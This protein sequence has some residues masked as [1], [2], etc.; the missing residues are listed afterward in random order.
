[1]TEPPL[2]SSPGRPLS[3]SPWIH[4]FVC[5]RFDLTLGQVVDYVTPRGALT[6]SEEKEVSYL[7]FP[8]S[9]TFVKN[10]CIYAIRMENGL[11]GCVYFRQK[12][13]PTVPRGVVQHSLVLLSVYPFITLHEDVLQVLST[14]FFQKCELSPEVPSQPRDVST[15]TFPYPS[16]ATRVVQITDTAVP[17]NITTQ[18]EILDLVWSRDIHAWPELSSNQVYELPLLGTI[19]RWVSP[20]RFHVRTAPDPLSPDPV[21]G[22]RC[23]NRPPT[24]QVHSTTQ[25]VQQ[26][27]K[28]LSGH[29]HVWSDIPL[30]TIFQRQLD[31]LPKL[32]ELL[33]ANESI[34]VLSPHPSICS[35]VV[36]GMCSLILPMQIQGSVHPYFTV[37]DTNLSK[38]SAM[39]LDKPTS[40]QFP[41]YSSIL[42]GCTNVYFAKFMSGWSNFLCCS[43]P[44]EMALDNGHTQQIPSKEQMASLPAREKVMWKFSDEFFVKKETTFVLNE[45]QTNLSK[46]LLTASPTKTKDR[47]GGVELVNNETLRRHFLNLTLDFLSPLQQCFDEIWNSMVSPLLL[48]DD[49]QALRAVFPPE[50]FLEY[51]AKNP[52]NLKKIFKRFHN[53]SIRRLYEKFLRGDMFK[54]W[55]RD[56]TFEAYRNDLLHTDMTA[57]VSRKG[58][59][60]IM[61]LF[62]KLFQDWVSVKG[63]RWIV[64]EEVE[65]GLERQLI[66]LCTALPTHLANQLRDKIEKQKTLE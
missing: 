43:G 22:V 27:L 33:I 2:N 28:S 15:V 11:N 23:S 18:K 35:G 19:L 50:I 57:M 42:L 12:R 53:K 56:T 32:W 37:Q 36:L 21:L 47:S 8:D 34:M 5:I 40:L 45:A 58:E 62:L 4:C 25:H 48:P 49:D 13:D 65:I 20:A 39:G 63:R 64:D 44:I 9:N 26:L 51:L 46:L 52:N 29:R 24:L 61:D 17:P 54:A 30:H 7:G 16:P 66:S 1:M 10:D 55:L 6:P 59:T 3:P 38:Y 31:V 41:L 60:Q 14:Y